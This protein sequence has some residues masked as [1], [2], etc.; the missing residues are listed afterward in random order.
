MLL[1][2]GTAIVLDMVR[3]K[4]QLLLTACKSE[5]GPGRPRGQAGGVCRRDRRVREKIVWAPAAASVV[6]A[7]ERA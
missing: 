4:A 2:E 3:P 5:W 7:I 6:I 1:C